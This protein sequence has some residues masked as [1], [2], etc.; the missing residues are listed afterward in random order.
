M[1]PLS[2]Y[3]E[4]EVIEDALRAIPDYRERIRSTGV[5]NLD[6]CVGLELRRV[7]QLFRSAI[8][9]GPYSRLSHKELQDMEAFTA[10]F[11]P[12]LAARTL[13]YQQ[14]YMQQRRV[15]RINATTAEAIIPEAFRQA[16]L[17]ATVTGQRY[18]AKVTVA[19]TGN[20]LRFY[21]SYKDM[22]REG[23]LDEVVRSVL[24]IQDAAT[25]LGPG[26]TIS[27]K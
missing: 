12:L 2:E 17:H 14:R 15:A 3:T 22:N 20:Y 5:F 21:L 11:I 25:R 9:H 16:G 27:K 13:P 19:I 1:K 4:E 7:E 26:L 23:V 8:G 18:R 10:H 24:T 6:N